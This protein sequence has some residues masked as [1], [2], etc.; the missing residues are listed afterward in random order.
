MKI[1]GIHD[2]HNAAACLVEDG[3]VVA[4]LQEERLTRSKNQFS[5]PTGAIRWV[6]ESTGTDPG[7]I[8]FV[9]MHSKHVPYAKT[10]E[11]MLEEYA[12]S[13]SLSYAFRQIMKKTPATAIHRRSR[14]ED[15]LDDI[16]KAGLPAERALFIDHHT[17]HAAAAFHG[18]PWKDREVLVLTCDGMGDDL[19]ASVRIGEK[20]RLGDP[21][22]TIDDSHSLGSIYA[23]ITFVMGM[24]PNEHEYKLMGMAPYA[25]ESGAKISYGKFKNLFHF[26]G[27]GL[28]WEREPGIPHTY[29]SYEFFKNLVARQ[30]FD[31]IAAGLQ[32]WT[33]EH[34]A[35]WAANA[36][37]ETGVHHLA[38]GGG[39]FM[40]VKANKR[41]YEMPEVDGLFVFPSCGDE[42]NCIGAAFRVYEEEMTKKG[43]PFE[44]PA[45][46][47]V[48]WGPETKNKDV[49]AMRSTLES[50][51]YEVEKPA[52]LD[53]KVGDMLADGEVVARACGPMEF[54]ARALGNRSILADPTSGDVVRIINDMIKNRDFWMPFAPA[55]L[56][57]RSDEYVVNP[58]KM[59]APYMIMTFDSTEKVVEFPA[60]VQPYDRSAR[61]QFVHEGQNP[62][63][64]RVISRFA[65]RTGRAV[66]LNTSFNLHGFPIVSSAADAI[67]VLERSGLENL[68]VAD[69]LI[70]KPKSA[71]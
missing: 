9:A 47:S 55:M 18:A 22:A 63:F 42:M 32:Q 5:F 45:L 26:V 66:V 36:V 50:K 58:K 41:I 39:V 46:G 59:D 71:S 31:W 53:T 21:I 40:N 70:R 6:L 4:A 2:G 65:E 68:A 48:Y 64:H 60:G 13:Q 61:P 35:T 8:D 69:Y 15:R 51:G 54:G 56:A 1:L 37:R 7:E 44:I 38:L 57:E 10:R 25:P 29:Y 34:L 14:R 43:S 52:D 16:R 67:D 3:V 23:K 49:E 11:E 62:G 30:R 17:A 20:G 27:N 24:V 12:A 19:C 28:T 33:E